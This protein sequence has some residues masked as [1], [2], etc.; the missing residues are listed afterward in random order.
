MEEMGDSLMTGAVCGLIM[1]E[2]EEMLNS[3]HTCVIQVGELMKVANCIFSREEYYDLLVLYKKFDSNLTIL[4]NLADQI[5]EPLNLLQA[6]SL[7]ATMKELNRE[8]EEIIK[9]LQLANER[10]DDS[11]VDINMAKLIQRFLKM[12]SFDS[13]H[14]EDLETAMEKTFIILQVMDIFDEGYEDTYYPF[15]YLKIDSF[16]NKISA[17]EH[18]IKKGISKDRIHNRYG[19]HLTT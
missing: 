18:A 2:L 4:E 19:A 11:N 3:C 17:Y 15:N 6:V 1:N 13:I 16:D 5:D 8:V 10:I 9:V 14:Y 7:K 12:D